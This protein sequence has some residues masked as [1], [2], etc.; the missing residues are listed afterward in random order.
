M[1]DVAVACRI[2]DA[3]RPRGLG[4]RG[5]CKH[6]R[7]RVTVVRQDEIGNVCAP[8]VGW[9]VKASVVEKRCAFSSLK[10]RGRRDVSSCPH[11]NTHAHMARA[12]RI[13]VR[14]HGAIDVSARAGDIRR[15][16]SACA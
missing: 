3:R 12:T 2:R 7:M 8:P 4:R 13:S 11:A 5:T 15:A 9:T 10:G 6:V 16:R 14:D 1:C